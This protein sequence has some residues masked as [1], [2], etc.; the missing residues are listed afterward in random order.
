MQYILLPLVCL[1]VGSIYGQQDGWT[2]RNYPDPITMPGL[3]GRVNP[4]FICDPSRILEEAAA[5][6]I[7]E[8][9]KNIYNETTV[10]CYASGPRASRRKGYMVMVAVMPKM[11]RYRTVNATVYN[12][13]TRYREAQYFAYHLGQQKKW[14]AH[15]SSCNE[16]VIILYSA[17]DGVLYTSTQSQARRLLTDGIVR[18]KVI[19]ALTLYNPI[20]RNN[21]V[22][23]HTLEYLVRQ[24]GLALRADIAA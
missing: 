19:W 2:V 5:D 22:L 6:Q 4:S 8:I 11:Q 1:F 15:S 13:R 12:M 17:E 9:A 24:Y 20:N 16:T 10:P 23:A 7:D 21:R 18:E 3:C 14:G